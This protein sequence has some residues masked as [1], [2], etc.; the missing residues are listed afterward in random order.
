MQFAADVLV[1]A[2][3]PR[4]GCPDIFGRQTVDQLI[5]AV[6]IGGIFIAAE[7][8]RERVQ[9]ERV[10]LE[11]GLTLAPLLFLDALQLIVSRTF[12]FDLLDL[13]EHGVDQFIDA[14][15]IRSE[16][17]RELVSRARDRKST[18]L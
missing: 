3:V 9:P 15:R 7:V 6:D 16:V 18:R 12:S 11:L 13:I 4:G 17:D 10:G 5:E 14:C 8:K 1:R 2:E